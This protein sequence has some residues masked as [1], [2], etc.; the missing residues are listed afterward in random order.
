MVNTR[1]L[2]VVALAAFVLTL[3]FI[4]YNSSVGDLVVSEGS[5]ST[6]INKSSDDLD[7]SSINKLSTTNQIVSPNAVVDSKKNNPNT[8]NKISNLIESKN[9]DKQDEAINQQISKLGSSSSSSSNIVIDEEDEIIPVKGGASSNTVGKGKSSSSSSNDVEDS[10]VKIVDSPS[11]SAAS[12]AS[13]PSGKFDPAKA[14]LEIR[15]LAPMIIFSKTY[16]PY[17]KRIKSLLADNYDISPKYYVVELDKHV[18]GA[19]LQA[20][21]AEVT[22]RATVPNVLVGAS[23]ESRGGADDFIKLHKDGLLAQSIQKWG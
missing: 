17:S 18:N 2:R 14:L 6:N 23:L 21:L 5:D 16:C 7:L 1:Q 4:L 22:G 10:N 19:E 9:N 11:V 3:I 8:P 13:S 12:A 15:S 20:H